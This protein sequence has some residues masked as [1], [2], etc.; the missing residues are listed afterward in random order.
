M[1]PS[2]KC[3]G[4]LPVRR[5]SF[6]K[7]QK[8]FAKTVDIFLYIAFGI[9]FGPACFPSGSA[10]IVSSASFSAIGCSRR[11]R[12][13]LNILFFDIPLNLFPSRPLFPLSR[14]SAAS[15]SMSFFAKIILY[16]FTNSPP[17][18]ST[19]SVVPSNSGSTPSFHSAR[20]TLFI[21]CWWDLVLYVANI[22]RVLTSALSLIKVAFSAVGSRVTS[23]CLSSKISLCILFS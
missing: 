11:S 15:W 17:T 9:L 3:A 4:I 8:G 13:S 12:P 18:W 6:I 19:F 14:S 2:R 1:S 20:F 21:H 7:A 23:G 16:S 10:S 22:A 5:V